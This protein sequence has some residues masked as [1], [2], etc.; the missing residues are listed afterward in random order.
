[1]K[2]KKIQIYIFIIFLSTIYLKSTAQN[3]ARINDLLYDADYY[4]FTG[5]FNKAAEKYQ[6]V[7]KFLPDNSNIL[8]KLGVCYLNSEEDKTKAIETLKKASENINPKYNP[9]NPKENAA[10]P[11]VLFLLGSAY[12]S[13]EKLDEAI[14]YYNKFLSYL[15][16]RQKK[17]K[18]LVEQYIKSCLN[19]KET[20][21]NRTYF[22]FQNLGEQ[23]NNQYNNENASLSGDGTTLIY[24]TE[25]KEGN[26]IFISIKKGNEW[27]KPKEIRAQLGNPGKNFK[28]VS[29]SFDGTML[30]I[31]DDDPLN[32]DLYF[33]KFEKGRWMPAKKFPFNSKYNETHAC[34]SLDN[35]RI[36]FTSDRPGGK[37]D[38]DI[39]Y[40]DIDAKGNF[41][42][43]VNF[44]E[45]NTPF[46]EETPFLTLDGKYLFFSSE[47]YNS[48]GGYD[49]FYV[50]LDDEN[51]NPIR[52][53][54]PLNTTDNDIFYFPVNEY[55]GL[56]SMVRTE[57]YGKKDIY[58][59]E[60][61]KL[62]KIE[63]T[64][65]FE[66][67]IIPEDKPI[68]N[69][70]NEEGN[71][72]N[73][74]YPITINKDNFTC[75]LPEGKYSIN[76]VVPGFQLFDSIILLAKD[77][78][79]EIPIKQEKKH[80]E[81]IASIADSIKEKVPVE[82]FIIKEKVSEKTTNKKTK[83]KKEEKF[84]RQDFIAD[85][86]IFSANK[87][88]YTIQFIALKKPKQ[89]LKFKELSNVFIKFT[90]TDNTYR[91]HT[92]IF[93]NIDDAN[94]YLD[95]VLSIGYKDAF[96]KKEIIPEYTVQFIA[97]KKEIK[98]KTFKDIKEYSIF[99]GKDGFYRFIYGKF[100]NTNSA[101]LG[102]K[103]LSKIGF[104]NAFI[105][106]FETLLNQ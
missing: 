67:N 27:T 6:E 1:M 41:G 62:F 13:I 34:F 90:S 42:K 21:K 33:S 100:H 103:E 48:I 87:Y 20:I 93:F 92:G 57:G 15:T 99:T 77:E 7:L 51:I 38:L 46:N 85:K 88:F 32:S 40:V 104:T 49:I 60:K 101:I 84:E 29:L 102:W 8:Y 58:W 70:I 45:I 3:W 61:I 53:D 72:L 76:I 30:I 56:K 74:E 14:D 71:I 95:Y 106:R 64:F 52:L 26:K 80:E 97:L 12:R 11:E 91:Y 2:F 50:K 28:S 16:P 73:N 79:L 22:K 37:G 43:I 105:R 89:P 36:Y 94:K 54:Y 83:I 18:I 55:S 47:G 44:A 10:P 86:E 24:T 96:I 66:N 25:S 63:G 59:I 68:V 69:I 81:Y 75:S 9:D 78:R 5:Q 19:A 23:I 98:W 17:E 39:Y 82:T 35:K 4:L 31:V 65:V